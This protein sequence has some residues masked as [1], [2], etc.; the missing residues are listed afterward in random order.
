MNEEKQNIPDDEL[1]WNNFISGCENAYKLLYERFANRLIVQGLQF[2]PDK[3]L[4]KDCVHDLFV[5]IYKNRANLKPVDKL[6]IYLFVGLR[7]SLIT[8]I[9]KRK[10]CLLN[11]E[12]NKENQTIENLSIEDELIDRET[13]D[14][15]IKRLAGAIS[16][17]TVRQKEVIL[18]R[19]YENLSLEEIAVLMNMNRQSVQ[20]LL[21][22]TLKKLRETKISGTKS[23]DCKNQDV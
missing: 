8:T 19:F 3:E 23:Q 14:L 20:N 7:N 13:R 10:K 1:L 22:R 17:L 4:I 18:Y 16:K 11:S 5:K 9:V 2:T 12:K 6:R 15:E 21:Q